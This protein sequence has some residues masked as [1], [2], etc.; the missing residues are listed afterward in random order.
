[1]PNILSS[2][3][4]EVSVPN[5][6]DF[7]D[8][9]DEGGEEDEED[10]ALRKALRPQKVKNKV[11]LPPIATAPLAITNAASTLSSSPENTTIAAPDL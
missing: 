5:P 4:L 9:G 1:M 11:T 3:L 10:E 8:F 2:Q 7:G 6:S